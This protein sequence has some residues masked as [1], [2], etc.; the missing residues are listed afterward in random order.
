LLGDSVIPPAVPLMRVPRRIGVSGTSFALAT[1]LVRHQSG[2][3]DL[4]ARASTL[5]GD[6]RLVFSRRR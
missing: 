3:R 4:L 6:Y 1:F 5:H 2:R